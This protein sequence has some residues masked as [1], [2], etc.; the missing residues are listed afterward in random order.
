MLSAFNQNLQKKFNVIDGFDF[1]PHDYSW[2]CILCGD[3]MS[4][5]TKSINGRINHFR[6]YSTKN[7]NYE[8]E[9]ETH[10]EM[11]GYL[12]E[13]FPKWNDIKLKDL[14]HNIDKQVILDVYFEL[15]DGYTIGIECQVSKMSWGEFEKRMRIYDEKNLFVIWIFHYDSFLSTQPLS[16]DY[17]IN[18]KYVYNEHFLNAYFSKSDTLIQQVH[19]IYNNRVYFYRNNKIFSISFPTELEI[20]KNVL[21]FSRGLTV[22]KELPSLNISEFLQK[23]GYKIALFNQ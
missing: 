17:E 6:H 5:V 9:S 20:I 15:N 12:Y 23:S 2:S 13:E 11:K 14:E 3:K 19:D 7:C 22:E 4:Y 18:S 10:L 8:Q 1:D 21:Y 16:F